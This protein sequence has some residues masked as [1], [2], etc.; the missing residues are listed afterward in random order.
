MLIVE[1]LF[2]EGSHMFH[3]NE[4]EYQFLTEALSEY[5]SDYIRLLGE[6]AGKDELAACREMITAIMWEL[7]TRKQEV[8][9]LR[10]SA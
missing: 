5:A 1:Y 10:K 8:I 3:L 7:Q 9:S 2:E 4:F 6:G